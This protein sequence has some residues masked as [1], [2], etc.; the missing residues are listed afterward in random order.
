M[1]ISL[2]I[3]KMKI[4]LMIKKTMNLEL[5]QLKG[6]TETSLKQFREHYKMNKHFCRMPYPQYLSIR[7]HI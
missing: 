2:M 6:Q 1:K 3:K 5:K 4:K 7:F